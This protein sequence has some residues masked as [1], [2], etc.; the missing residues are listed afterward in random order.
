MAVFIVGMAYGA[1]AT[2]SGIA[3]AIL[4][5]VKTDWITITYN[6]VPRK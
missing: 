6:K 1:F 4:V 3:L 5:G 2:I